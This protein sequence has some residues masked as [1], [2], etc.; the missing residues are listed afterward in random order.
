MQGG[1]QGEINT[2]QLSIPRDRSNTPLARTAR[3]EDRDLCL[4]FISVAIE[5][6][7][8]VF[9]TSGTKALGQRPFIPKQS[10]RADELPA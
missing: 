9:G 3:K 8:I 5:R 1:A 2:L 7:Q 6:G 10:N 4:S